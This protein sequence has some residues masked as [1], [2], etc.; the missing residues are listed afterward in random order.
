MQG[1]LQGNG[2]CSVVEDGLGIPVE[3]LGV[4]GCKGKIKGNW[5]LMV[6]VASSSI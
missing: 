5:W 4:V 3:L 1:D 2:R 6:K